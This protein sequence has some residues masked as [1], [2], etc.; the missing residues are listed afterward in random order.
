MGFLKS[1]VHAN[2]PKTIE[3]LKNNIRAEMAAIS[4]ETLANGIKDSIDH[5]EMTHPVYVTCHEEKDL[6]LQG[7]IL[8]D[9]R[10]K[11][12]LKMKNVTLK[13]M[14]REF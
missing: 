2:K 3:E 9:E 1:K 10:L 5:I 14:V 6:M 8:Q 4:P 11:E 7:K 13:E 12:R